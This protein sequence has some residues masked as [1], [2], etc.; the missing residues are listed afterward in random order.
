MSNQDYSTENQRTIHLII[1]FGHTFF[2]LLLSGEAIYLGWEMWAIPV[3]YL[4]LAVCWSL[5]LMQAFMPKQ[6]LW[7]YELMQMVMFFFYGVHDES[8]FDLTPVIVLVILAYHMTG[9]IGYVYLAIGTYLL[10]VLYDLLL[11]GGENT[12]LTTFKITRIVLHLSVVML[13]GYISR[14]G[15]AMRKFDEERFKKEVRELKDVNART[16][17]FL[18]NVSHEL[19][20]PINAVTGISA[21]LLKSDITGEAKM[22]LLSIRE[23]GHRLLEQIGDILDYT[24]INTGKMVISEDSYT[25]SS[26]LGDL[27]TEL[28]L[29]GIKTDIDILFDV[30][31]NVPAVLL[32]D[33]R[34][35]KKI[36]RH[37]IENAIKFTKVG[38]ARIRI[39]SVKKTYGINLLIEVSD[40][41]IGIVE[42]DLERITERFYQTDSGRSRAAGGLGLGLSIVSGMTGSMNGF[43]QVSSTKDVGTTV[44]ISIPQQVQDPLPC[45]VLEHP[46][47]INVCCYIRPGLYAN[48]Q[49]W[50][51]YNE[52]IGNMVQGSKVPVHRVTNISE[53]KHLSEQEELTHV[54]TGWSEYENDAAY[55]D[56][57]SKKTTVVVIAGEGVAPAKDSRIHILHRPIS[58]FPIITL[59]N[60]S[61]NGQE[62]ATAGKRL[63]CP[64]TRVLV[65]DD[66]VMNIV[67]ARGIFKEYR[68]SVE[69]AS[70]GTEAIELCKNRDYD[71]IFMDH[72]MPG[73]DG[74][75]TVHRIRKLPLA[76]EPV[77]VA[78]TANAVSGAREM[79]LSEGFDEFLSKPIESPELERVLKKM[80]PASLIVYEDMH[81][82]LRTED[83]EEDSASGNE[84]EREI[85]GVR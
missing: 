68:I 16:E 67:V 2:T 77:I 65:V 37:L 28:K 15:I 4:G 70:S 1:L 61:G 22:G 79:F 34:K 23:A 58:P 48:A 27:Q 52:M 33:G 78:L 7:I 59:L 73:M 25:I 21:V 63:L 45:M 9:M 56:M 82:N 72:M 36:I 30:D 75:E 54:L 17:D 46:D 11:L 39:S 5:H 57:L 64:G 50:D 85:G 43:M 24:E 12:T 3:V 53:L 47:E 6:R 18:T 14:R 80:L 41:G 26:L 81:M 55:L 8:F 83:A 66:E 31:V 42:A 20:T 60:A 19:R 62:S 35:I 49:V 76:K 51:F 40:T 38:G 44:R 32:G 84:E 29:L 13:A 69:S 71:L 10:T 74:V